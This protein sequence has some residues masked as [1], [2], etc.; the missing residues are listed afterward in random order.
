MRKHLHYFALALLLVAF[1][2][3]LLLWG[4]V[5][6]LPQVGSLIEHSAANEAL[7]ASIYLAL[8]H[9]LD[10]AIPAFGS[11]G[12]SMM[13]SGLEEGF[14]RIVEAPNLAMDVILNASFN[15]TH[16]WIKML[17][18]APPILLVAFLILWVIRPKTVNLVRKR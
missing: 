9:P 8:G 5:P 2:W 12:A 18:W 11:L 7:L 10:S 14:A 4:A 15:R 1:L 6:D 13:T 16:A 17:Y 3:D